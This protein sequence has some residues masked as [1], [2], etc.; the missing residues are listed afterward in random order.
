MLGN[1]MA[2][3]EYKIVKELTGKQQTVLSIKSVN[4]NTIE[5][6]DERINRWK[7]HFQTVLNCPKPTIVHNFLQ[8]S[9]DITRWK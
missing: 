6:F 4:G 9:E 5:T 3:S 1:F 7:K 2:Y 8:D